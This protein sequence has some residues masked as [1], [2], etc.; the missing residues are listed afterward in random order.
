MKTKKGVIFSLI[1][2]GMEMCWLY[3][4][5]AFSMTAI[6]DKPF[7]SAGAIG[8]FVLAAILT[9][10]SIGRGWRIIQVGG[11]QALGFVCVALGTLHSVYYSSY[12]LTDRG[13]ISG[14][15][16]QPRA[17][18]E[19]FNFLLILV[20]ML[21]F[22]IGGCA[23]ARRPRAYFTVCARFDIGLVAFFCLFLAR[24]VLLDKGGI[25]VDDPLSSALIFPF[26]L[27]SLLAIGMARNENKAR[28]VF[29]PGYRSFGIIATFMATVILSAGAVILFFL[30]F[31]TAVAGTGY[32]ALKVGA[33]FV[34][35]IVERFLRYGFMGR[36]VREE[37][38]GSSPKPG[39]WDHLFSMHGP[40]MELIEKVIKW[41]IKSIAVLLLLSAFSV[42]IY[43]LIKWLL[44]KTARAQGETGE[45]YKTTPWFLRLWTV[46][47]LLCRR[48]FLSI[49]GYR[50]ATELYAVLLG[51]GK[52]SGLARF[53]H[54]TPLEFGAR[55]DK[56]FPQLKSEIDV[57][58]SAFNT[59]IYG[60]MNMSGKGMKKALSAWRSLRSPRHWPLR[61]KTC[62][63]SVNTKE[64]F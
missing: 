10:L 19:W 33:G 57:I 28:K 55:L 6:M 3:G 62:F 49:R 39:E 14:L 42:I 20:W 7:S 8:A 31:L 60:E 9:H 23:Q 27:L 29:L 51:W 30:P 44:S 54:E 1:T 36:S 52:R 17:P 32:R 18:M 34:L 46:L 35:P 40:W 38:A 48:L 45:T 22:W 37:P 64:E 13:W 56:H 41:G 15:F 21:L 2:G 61:L 25:R 43:Y 4:W 5:A 11:L 50:K 53:I 24:L 47:V 59:E 63:L 58:V 26:F 12:L 16:H